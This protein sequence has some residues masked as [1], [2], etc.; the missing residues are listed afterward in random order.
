LPCLPFLH[1]SLLPLALGEAQGGR[2]H[3]G[4]LVIA[5][6]PSLCRRGGLLGHRDPLL[7]RPR[8]GLLRLGLRFRQRLSLAFR[9]PAL[10]LFLAR[11]ALLAA[12]LSLLLPG[13]AVFLLR[14]ALLVGDPLALRLALF[15]ALLPAR[16]G[17]L[18]GLL[19]DIH[20]GLRLG[21]GIGVRDR[22]PCLALLVQRL[23]LGLRLLGLGP[24]FLL[25]PPRVL[26]RELVDAAPALPRAAAEHEQHNGQQQD[27]RASDRE[28]L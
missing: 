28:G 17:L 21:D 20:V 6:P 1:F 7:L 2:E 25:C 16:L 22:G 26:P 27:D 9:L 23:R 24:R 8:G 19:L 13:A 5:V 12:A 15:P 4:L 10:A 11:L 3:R 18:L 14:A